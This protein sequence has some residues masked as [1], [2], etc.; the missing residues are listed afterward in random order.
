M[1][2]DVNTPRHGGD[3]ISIGASSNRRAD[4]MLLL[5]VFFFYL[6][7]SFLFFGRGLIGHFS[8]RFIGRDADPSQMMWLLKWWPYAL[9]HRLSPFLTNY[10]WG[11]VGFNLAVMTSIPLPAL[12]AAPFTQTIGVVATYNLLVL[13]AIALAALSAFALC[14]RITHALWPSIFGGFVF[15]FSS[16]MVAHTLNHFCLLLI[17]PLPLAAYLV[18]RCLE[19]SIS[20]FSFTALMTAALLAEFLFEPDPFTTAAVVG[21]GV[22]T[23]G[24]CY[25]SNEMRRSLARTAGLIA[26]SY[27]LTGLIL[28]PYLYYF[29]AFGTLHQL[30]WPAERFSIDLLNW[31]T[32]T[33]ANLI[34]TLKPFSQMTSRFSGTVAERDGY[35]ALPL[36]AIAISWLRRHWPA[37]LAK[38]IAVSMAMVSVGA[39]GPFLQVAGR[40]LV[41]MP[42]LAIEHLP[43]VQHTLPARLM[44]FP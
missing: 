25:S 16:Y 38:T 6:T 33:E 7:L 10:V 5:G 21:A 26:I 20:A 1:G 31:F 18:V 29:F 40:V 36:L 3:T 13:L 4:A 14:R 2:D 39:L 12:L 22:L 15:G 41:P 11:A 23:V 9:A 28:I 35:V 43:L 24:F 30:F 34:G 44:V 42:W 27:I 19:G 17:F 37:P 8:D 32:P